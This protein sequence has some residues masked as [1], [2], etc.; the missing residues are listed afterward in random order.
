V[1][2]QARVFRD[3]PG[4]LVL[5]PGAAPAGFVHQPRVLRGEAYCGAADGRGGAHGPGQGAVSVGGG[6]PHSP[7]FCLRRW[8][9]GSWA[10]SLGQG[11]GYGRGDI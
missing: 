4:A 2:S 1:R 7:R 6:G 5:D 8:L 11:P 3:P 9:R 10:V